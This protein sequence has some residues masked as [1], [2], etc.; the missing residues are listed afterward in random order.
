MYS[1]SCIND[2]C[3]CT[4]PHIL[5]ANRIPTNSKQWHHISFKWLCL[6]AFTWNNARHLITY[7]QMIRHTA[8]L[9][10]YSER[11]ISRQ[12]L[13]CDPLS[14]LWCCYYNTL[15]FLL[16]KTVFSGIM[17]AVQQSKMWLCACVPK[18]Q[19]MCVWALL[20]KTRWQWLAVLTRVCLSTATKD[21]LTVTSCTDT[22]V[23]EH[24]Y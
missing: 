19:N 24:C 12:F 9:L 14:L 7:Q 10:E 17:L 2:F 3:Y 22:C 23:S 18:L 1:H 20:L 8:V 15:T 4:W 5:T 13:P 21:T 6:T 16:L 11:L